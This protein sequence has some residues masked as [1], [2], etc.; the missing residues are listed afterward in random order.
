MLGVKFG[1][2]PGEWCLIADV[3]GY[4]VC[5]VFIGEWMSTHLWRWNRHSVPKRLLLNT[6]RR[7]QPKRLHG[8]VWKWLWMCDGWSSVEGEDVRGNVTWGCVLWEYRACV[9]VHWINLAWDTGTLNWMKQTS[10]CMK[11]GKRLEQLG[12]SQLVKRCET[13]HLLASLTPRQ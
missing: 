7:E 1:L 11:R 3:S 8:T 12:Y 4:C 10:C 5:S 9:C 13:Q 2:F 6:T